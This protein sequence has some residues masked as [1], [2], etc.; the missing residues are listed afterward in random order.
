MRYTSFTP[1]GFLRTVFIRVDSKLI[2]VTE[3]FTPERDGFRRTDDLKQPFQR[4]KY[5]GTVCRCRLIGG[6][7]DFAHAF[8]KDGFR[9]SAARRRV[10]ALVAHIIL[11]ITSYINLFCTPI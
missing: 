3:A 6:L 5:T 2:K 7:L 9:S 1:Y 8:T 4:S 11:L 10:F